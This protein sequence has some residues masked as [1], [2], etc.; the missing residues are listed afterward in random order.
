M[1]LITTAFLAAAIIFCSTQPFI[2]GPPNDDPKEKG[3]YGSEDIIWLQ[4]GVNTIEKMLEPYMTDLEIYPGNFGST[5]RAELEPIVSTVKDF[6]SQEEFEMAE[7]CISDFYNRLN[8]LKKEHSQE[9]NSSTL[10]KAVDGL[11]NLART[12]YIYLQ[13]LSYNGLAP[14]A[15]AGRL[16]NLITTISTLPHELTLWNLMPWEAF[17]EAIYSQMQKYN[18]K[19]FQAEVGSAAFQFKSAL[20]ILRHMSEEPLPPAPQHHGS[21]LSELQSCDPQGPAAST[22]RQRLNI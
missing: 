14:P 2:A 13:A 7:N 18:D 21:I 9:Y 16:Q 6:I 15:E 12:F 17:V 8:E 10:F 22:S 4:N 3:A 5:V 20:R 11:R 19:E 1:K